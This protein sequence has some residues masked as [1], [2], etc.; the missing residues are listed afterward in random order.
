MGKLY[1]QGWGVPQ[2]FIAAH[3]WFNLAG[4]K[5]NESAGKERDLVERRMTSDQIAQAQK[6]AREWQPGKRDEWFFQRWFRSQ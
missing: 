1:R 6:L 4:A 5:G 3:V 2:D